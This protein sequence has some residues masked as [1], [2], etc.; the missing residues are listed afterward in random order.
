MG[1][2]SSLRSSILAFSRLV[3]EGHFNREAGWEV[4]SAA[5]VDRRAVIDRILGKGLKVPYEILPGCWIYT[6]KK[7][8]AGQYVKGLFKG[9]IVFQ[10]YP[11]YIIN[12]E[13]NKVKN[14]AIWLGTQFGAQGKL[15]PANSV[16]YG[17]ID[18]RK[19]LK[20]P[21]PPADLRGVASVETIQKG[22]DIII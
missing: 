11:F 18:P 22:L 19:T 5:L 4:S 1:L 13:G 8:T 20:A 6:G 3:N 9:R 16:Y 15:L 12:G 7:T 21:Q 14:I 17:Y 10:Y 2:S